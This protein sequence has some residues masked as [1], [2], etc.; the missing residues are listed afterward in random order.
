[1]ADLFDWFGRKMADS[2][3]EVAT[4][5]DE[6]AIG[7]NERER[8]KV[9]V[10]EWTK[11]YDERLMSRGGISAEDAE[12]VRLAAEFADIYAY[13][14]DDPEGSADEEMDYWTD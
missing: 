14:E 5:L 2:L 8:E 3:I 7:G 1:M 4:L 11:R 10:E 13:Y 6:L 12:E 9:T